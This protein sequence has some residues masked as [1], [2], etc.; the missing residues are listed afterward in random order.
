ME[1]VGGSEWRRWD[2]HIHTPQTL[3]NDNYVGS[4]SDEKWDAFYTAVSNYVGDGSD[5]NRAIAAVGITDYLSIDNYLKVCADHRLPDTIKLILPNVEMRLTLTAQE[6][7]VNIHMI[8]DPCIVDALEDRFFGKL[9]F[10][11]GDTTFSATK[12]EL[13][14]FGKLMDNSS[15]NEQAER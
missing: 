1:Y 7:P 15:T 3:K 10:K 11:Y 13:I 6:S 8:F 9:S 5:R 2:L 4:T 14:R 12:S